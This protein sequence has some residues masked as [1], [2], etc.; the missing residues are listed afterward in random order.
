MKTHPHLYGK[1]YGVDQLATDLEMTSLDT[2]KP[3][4][5][6]KKKQAIPRVVIETQKRGKRKHVTIVSGLETVDASVDL[7]KVA[8]QFASKFA[9]GT[10]VGKTVEGK[11]EIVVQGEFAM[12]IME[13]LQ[14]QF[15][16]SE[17]LVTMKEGK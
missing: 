7:K 5:V 12:E 8:K 2:D 3:Q 14:D 16:V 9:C 11:D 15:N 13:I 10:G 17:D 4:V 6:K 1:L